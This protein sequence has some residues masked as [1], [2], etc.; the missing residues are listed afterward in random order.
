MAG[1][2]HREPPRDRLLP[3]LFLT[4]IVRDS[5]ATVPPKARIL[6]AGRELPTATVVGCQ[7]RHPLAAVDTAALGA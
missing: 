3:D 1:L 4:L 5:I 6:G 7:K 2:G